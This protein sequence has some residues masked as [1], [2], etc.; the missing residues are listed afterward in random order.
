[1]KNKIIILGAGPIG[2]I[3]GWLLS[4]SQWEVDIYEKNSLVGGMCRSWTW[5]NFIL[6]T[7][8]HIFHT[9]DKK[10]WKFWNK[11]FGHLLIKG[12]FWSKNTYDNDFKNL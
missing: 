5:K 12:K 9:P 3:T 8:P 1:M 11:N 10:M 6:D 4:K 2:L 7:G